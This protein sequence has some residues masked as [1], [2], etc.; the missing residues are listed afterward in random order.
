MATRLDVALDHYADRQKL[1]LAT[2]QATASIWS[3]VDPN[4]IADSW[5][6]LLPE[7]VAVVSGAQL[8]AAR[9]ASSYVDEALDEDMASVGEVNPAGFA[10]QA[11]DAR[12][13]VGLLTN[14]VVVTLLTIQDGM[15]VVRAL[16]AGRQ[17]LTMLAATQVADAGRLADQAALTSRPAAQGYYRMAVGNSC[18]RCLIL[19]GAFYQW[20]KGFQRHPKCDCIHVPAGSPRAGAIRSPRQAY[21]RM[22]A[23]ERTRAGFTRADQRAIADGADLTQ[24]VNAHRGMYTAGGRKLTTEGTTRRGLF[25]QFEVDPETGAL[26]ARPKGSTQPRL[27]VDEIYRIA[28]G[29]RDEAIRLLGENAYLRIGEVHLPRRQSVRLAAE[30]PGPPTVAAEPALVR[31][32]LAAE[33]TVEGVSRAAAQEARA[34]AGRDIS[35]ALEGD[36]QI[37]REHA[38]GVLRGLE[39][40]PDSNLATVYMSDMPIGYGASFSRTF[41]PNTGV[42]GTIDSVTFSRRWAADPT[43]YR[44]ALARS[45]VDRGSVYRTPMDVATHEFGHILD[46]EDA[47]HDRVK[48]ALRTAA[49]RKGVRADR[50]VRTQVSKY[51]TKEIDELIAEAFTDVMVNGP[52]ASQ[53]SREIFDLLEAEYRKGGRRVGSAVVSASEPAPSA[54]ARAAEGLRLSLT[55]EQ[56]QTVLTGRTL[57]ELKEIA[58]L[59]RVTLP[60]RITKAKAADELVQQTVGR[61]LTSAAILGRPVA[62]GV[63]AEPFPLPEP[64]VRKAAAP[65][66]PRA[67]REPKVETPPSATAEATAARLNAAASR[68]EAAAMLREVRS[69]GELRD[70]AKAAGVALPARATRAAIETE[71]VRWT[72]GARL[73][74]DAV[75]GLKRTPAAVRRSEVLDWSASPD[76]ILAQQRRIKE[77]ALAGP[78]VKLQE[79]ERAA[80]R[81]ARTKAL[82]YYQRFGDEH[83]NGLLR[84]GKVGAPGGVARAKL[85][86][87]ETVQ[88]SIDTM[89][90]IFAD[91]KL[92]APITVYR[93]VSTPK[94]LFPGM[95]EGSLVGRSFT[96]KG[97]TSTSADRKIAADFVP[98]EGSINDGVMLEIRVPEG[99]GAIQISNDAYNGNAPTAQSSERE[100]LLEPG[101]RFRVVSDSRHE[102][103]F[104]DPATRTAK[105]TD[106]TS[107]RHLVVEVERAVVDNA[108]VRTAARQRQAAIDVATTRADT[109]TELDEL[110]ANRATPRALADVIDRAAVAKALTATDI[111][112]LRRAAANPAKAQATLDRIA[113]KYELTGVSRAGDITKMRDGFEVAAGRQLAEGADVRIVRRGSEVVVNGER[114]VLSRPLVRE[115]T[116]AELAQIRQRAIDEARAFLAE[117]PKPTAAQLRKAGIVKVDA[118]SKTKTVAFDPT[119]HQVRDGAVPPTGA[120]VRVV[121]PGYVFTYRGGGEVL[122]KP[123]VEV[124]RPKA[125]PPPSALYRAEGR[126]LAGLVQEVPTDTRR[127]GGGFSAY[128]ERHEFAD[129]SIAVQKIYG[130]RFNETAAE[131][132]REMDAEELGP[133]VYRALGIDAPAVVRG[134]DRGRLLMDFIEGQTGSEMGPIYLD[135]LTTEQGRRLGLV[136]ILV[137]NIDRNAGNFIVSPDGRIV[138]IDHADAFAGNWALSEW[139]AHLVERHPSGEVVLRDSVD[140]SGIDLADVRRRIQ[141]LESEFARLGRSGWYAEMLRKLDAIERA[142]RR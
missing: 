114:V 94:K 91:S 110:L 2:E 96:D 118:V 16:T 7:T 4:R 84:R 39:R 48:D 113:K 142:A 35:I 69:V 8:A 104:F 87:A 76:E 88:K 25:R 97:F 44:H 13:L 18:A 23:A 70:I 12:G 81:G 86:D 102:D 107:Y 34:I 42:Q 57:T 72:V 26:K 53:L 43:G 24:V 123:T 15:D 68:E 5:A 61:R 45:A 140:V 38:E 56:A 11:S 52:A 78:P 85:P 14:P 92:A 28:A 101:L 55:R 90:E 120:K 27:S 138:S 125:G 141:S 95:G 136:D 115:V 17:N 103:V 62:P 105:R 74:S 37:A 63:V 19:A 137:G 32:S 99:T 33:R 111:T 51:A 30:L 49:R 126:R 1:V 129:G 106:G 66:A 10:G 127:L 65:K 93:G 9:P 59:S 116:E 133:L 67:P 131:V 98:G 121:E 124:V 108:A 83:M 119:R 41:D 80:P 82:R 47:V 46:A 40:Y 89:R 75:S 21:D 64:R 79:L 31:R 112:S 77:H 135:L 50:L 71:L 139:T 29:D 22:T 6:Q 100:I 109:L 60:A 36:V 130:Q 117:T 54:A 132:R 58:R 134:G 128:V 20:N 73:V 122:A 3:E